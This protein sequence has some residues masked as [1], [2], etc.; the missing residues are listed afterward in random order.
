M[1]SIKLMDLVAAVS[2]DHFAVAGVAFVD[3]ALDLVAVDL[4]AVAG[5]ADSVCPV[6]GLVAVFV[7]PVDLVVD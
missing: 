4:V 7:G 3:P 6:V 2:A 1:N 5:F